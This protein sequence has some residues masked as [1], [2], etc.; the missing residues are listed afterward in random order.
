VRS[1]LTVDD[2]ID[3]L[4]REAA[5]MGGDAI[6][7]IETNSTGFWQSLPAQKLI[8]NA[9]VRV[10]FRAKVVVFLKPTNSYTFNPK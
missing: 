8:K 6:T 4:K 10:N 5:I 9:Y 3:K 2:A 7:E 1:A